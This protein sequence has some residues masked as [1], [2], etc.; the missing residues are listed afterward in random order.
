M[1]FIGNKPSAVPLTSADIAD[2]I[3][4]SAKIVDGTIVNADINASAAIVSTK[5]SGVT[6]PAAFRNI[7]INGD[8]QVAQRSTSTASIS[9]TGYYT[10]DRWYL[11]FSSLGTWTMSQSTDVPSGYGFS[12][13]LKLDCTTA[14]ASPA[15]G[16]YMVLAQKFEGQNLQYLKKGT[17]NALSLTASFWVKST[18]TGTFICELNDLDNSRSISKSYTVSVSNTWEFKTITFAGD[19]TGAFDNDNAAS[20]EINWFLGAGSN[21]TSGTLQTSWGTRTAAN[22]AVGQVNIADSTSNDF[23]ITGVQLEAGTSA[24]DFEFLP[25]DVSKKRCKRYFQKTTTGIYRF[26]GSWIGLHWSGTAHIGSWSTDTELRTDSTLAYAGSFQV[27]GG[28][29][30]GSGYTPSGGN[31]HAYGWFQVTMNGTQRASDQTLTCYS[32]N[33]STFISFDAEL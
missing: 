4:T 23:L 8:M 33:A 32:E 26:Q 9:T 25:I 3:I 29:G 16:D 17:A 2:G 6:S 18:K 30:T 28:G 19:T 12:K 1:P 14:D 24:T 22:I 20:L 13:S 5:L 27:L 10:L 21:T 7:V 11:G 31:Q 15:G